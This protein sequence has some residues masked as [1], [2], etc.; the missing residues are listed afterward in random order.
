MSGFATQLQITFERGRASSLRTCRHAWRRSSRGPNE[1]VVFGGRRADC[2]IARHRRRRGDSF[3]GAAC[4]VGLGAEVAEQERRCE[5]EQQPGGPNLDA[6]AYRP[7]ALGTQRSVV[8]MPRPRRA[9]GDSAATYLARCVVS[10]RVPIRFAAE[11]AMLMQ[12]FA[13]DPFVPE[14]RSAPAIRGTSASRAGSLCGHERPGIREFPC[15]RAM[16]ACRPSAAAGRRRWHV[17]WRD[18]RARATTHL[19]EPRR[20]LGVMFGGSA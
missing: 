6:R 20:C 17:V 15:H 14:F 11:G 16:V 3:R 5:S 4:C 8:L 1:Q 12:L 18:C 2:P 9:R 13:F 7:R 19:L 10:H